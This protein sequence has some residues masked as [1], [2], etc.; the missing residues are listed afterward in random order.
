M[1]YLP[2]LCLSFLLMLVC[3]VCATPACAFEFPQPT[4]LSGD[5]VTLTTPTDGP[6]LAGGWKVSLRKGPFTKDV[7]ALAADVALG[8]HA[9]QNANLIGQNITVTGTVG[10][11]LGAAGQQ[12]LLE[13][14]AVVQGS[15]WLAG[16]KVWIQGTIPAAG[17]IL[18]HRVVLEGTVKAAPAG[19]QIQAEEL[20]ILPGAKVEGNIIYRGKGLLRVDDRAVVSGKITQ[21]TSSYM[22]DVKQRLGRVTKWLKLGGKL[23]LVL[24]LL[25]AG[26]IVTLAMT[27]KVSNSMRQ[28]RRHPFKLM[29][30]GFA[31]LIGSPIA[32]ILLFISVA[33]MPMAISML[34]GYPLTI[35]LGFAIGILWFGALVFELLFKRRPR[36]RHELLACY[37]LAMPILLLLTKIPLIGGFIWLVPLVAGLGA[38]SWLKWRQMQAGK[39]APSDS[40]TV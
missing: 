1:K 19:L 24:W 4:V 29:A 6:V 12:V 25:V 7:Y 2:T 26:M 30:V 15:V 28:V 32:A 20:E 18:A 35:L 27:A 9:Q 36:R 17:R 3:G 5:E 31:Y 8:G 14:K 16:Q 13:P 37:V 40:D 10:G 34:A 22:D 11:N 21:D 33:G 38:V 39:E 23:M